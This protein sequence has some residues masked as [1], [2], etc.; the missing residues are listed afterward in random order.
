ML[1]V[2]E[3]LCISCG[4]CARSC[5]TGAIDLTFGK[6]H[7]DERKCIQ[8]LRCKVVCPQGAIFEVAK[9]G[10]TISLKELKY[11]IQNL[12]KGIDKILNRIERL[13]GKIR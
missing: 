5:P 3:E 1:K 12:E 10:V 6:A 13:K 9:T 2:K 4:L 11:N 8:C 7:I